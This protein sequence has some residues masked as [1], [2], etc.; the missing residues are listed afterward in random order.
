M[1]PLLAKR[2]IAAQHQVTRCRKRLAHC[3][4]KSRVAVGSCAV[5]KHNGISVPLFRRK[6]NALNRRSG[7]TI[8]KV[9]YSNTHA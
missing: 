9:C 3:R 5:R 4:Q 2:K 7:G 1:R 8:G 6:Q